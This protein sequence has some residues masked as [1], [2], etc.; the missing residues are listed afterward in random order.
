MLPLG[1]NFNCLRVA[2]SSCIGKISLLL[3]LFSFSTGYVGY[4]GGYQYSAERYK[5]CRAKN[6]EMLEAYKN[7]GIEPSF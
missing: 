5:G 4:L 7:Y 3:V 1:A 6:P 2:K